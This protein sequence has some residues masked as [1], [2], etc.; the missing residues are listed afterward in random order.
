VA[1]KL[2][3]SLL[4]YAAFGLMAISFRGQ[5]VFLLSAC[6]HSLTLVFLGMFVASSAGEIL[7]NRDEA[8]I[9]MHRPIAP[10][11]LLWAKVRVLGEISVYLAGAFNLAGLLVGAGA[12]DGDWRYVPVHLVSTVMQSF[13]CTGS[14]VMVYQLCLRWFGRERLDGLMTT[15]QVM[16][17]LA[18]VLVSQMLPAMFAF[19]SA[20][21][22]S[23]TGL[24][25]VLVLP[26]AWFAG[27]DDALAGSGAG[28]SWALAAIGCAATVLVLW[29]A[30]GK[31]AQDYASG[32]QMLNEQTGRRRSRQGRRRWVEA[33]ANLPLVRWWLRDPQERA[34]FLLTT[35]YLARDRDIK[36]RVYPALAPFLVFPII[37]M[38]KD[39]SQS[40]DAPGEGFGVV[41]ASGYLGVVPLTAVNLLQFSQHWQASDLFRIAPLAGP[42]PLCHGARKAVLCLLTAP[43][44]IALAAGAWII[45]G[46]P[47]ALVLLAPGMIVLPVVA[48]VPNLGG[49]SVPLSQPVEEA[50]SAS[51]GLTMIVALVATMALAG[52]AVAAQHKGCLWGLLAVETAVAALVYWALHRSLERAPWPPL[53]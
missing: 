22:T 33:L 9:L 30:L 20:A 15:A 38:M 51:R 6:L 18:A 40:A 4:F 1:R 50:K 32:L 26:P 11:A 23:L 3:L 29:A 12:S 36:L 37:F 43:L 21:Q 34:A 24:W 28:R 52:L 19:M 10:Q 49:R 45:H 25:F 16:I 5:P 41:F 31:L 27:L 42:A 44:A 8:D 17:S 48:I 53:D 35:A 39:L 13:F 2:A 7:F 14:V 46:D 47:A